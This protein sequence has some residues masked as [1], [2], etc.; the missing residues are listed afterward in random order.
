M[1]YDTFDAISLTVAILKAIK[2]FHSEE[3]EILENNF[4]DKLY[5]SDELRK[6]INNNSS[7]HDLTLTWLH[8]SGKFVLRS[9]PY[10]LY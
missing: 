3:F 10:R 9:A 8:D 1:E 4:I 6:N 7:I 5:G 2:S